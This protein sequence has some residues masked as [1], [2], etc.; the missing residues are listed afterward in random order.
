MARSVAKLTSFPL[1]LQSSGEQSQVRAT[2][3]AVLSRALP[4]ICY[5]AIDRTLNVQAIMVVD[6]DACGPQLPKQ[7]AVVLHQVLK[8]SDCA[9]ISCAHKH[10]RDG[11]GKHIE[12]LDDGLARSSVCC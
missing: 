10:Q 2:S 9:G 7:N 6:D 4:R 3:V 12:Q 8:T 1:R 5:T 11:G